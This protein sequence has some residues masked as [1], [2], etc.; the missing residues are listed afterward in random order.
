MPGDI[1]LLK[2]D[3][4]QGKRKVKDMW[5][6]VEYEVICQVMIDVPAYKVCDKG[7]NVKVI[8]QN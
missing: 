7:R 6:N 8:H 1:V 5:G 4:F 3:V 2:L